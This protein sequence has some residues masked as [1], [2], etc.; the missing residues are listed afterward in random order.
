MDHDLVTFNNKKT[1][2]NIR[3]CPHNEFHVNPTIRLLS[4]WYE[5]VQK[6]YHGHLRDNL[7]CPDALCNSLTVRRTL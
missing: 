3:P 5:I 4:F 6:W 7:W 2:E 1:N